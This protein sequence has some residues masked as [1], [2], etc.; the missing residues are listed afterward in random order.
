MFTTKQDFDTFTLKGHTF[1]HGVPIHSLDFVELKGGRPGMNVLDIYRAAGL[2]N[3]GDVDLGFVTKAL[4]AARTLIGKLMGWD[5]V[6]KLVEK[7]SY[8]S[9]I[10]DEDRNRSLI[11]PGTVEG[12]SRVLYCFENEMLLEIINKTVHCFWLLASEPAAN[13]Y[14]LYNAVYVKKLNW[15]TPIYMT[16]ISPVLKWVIYPAIMRSIVSNWANE[17]PE[18]QPRGRSMVAKAGN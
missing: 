16:L 8:L 3:M 6:P 7:V 2:A 5:N 13:G 14:E 15:R 11:P 17:F 10:T 9:R 18:G 4:L 12:I 1:L